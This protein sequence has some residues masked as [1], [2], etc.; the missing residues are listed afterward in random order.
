[1]TQVKINDISESMDTERKF[2]SIKS[3]YLWLKTYLS[4]SKKKKNTTL[5]LFQALFKNLNVFSL[6]NVIKARHY[7]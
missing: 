2:Y 6:G 1:M 3:P 7:R 5:A 4:E